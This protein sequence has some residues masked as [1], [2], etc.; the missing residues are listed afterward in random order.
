MAVIMLHMMQEADLGLHEGMD[1]MATL[2]QSVISIRQA[3]V[4]DAQEIA[5]VHVDTW[6][7][8]YQGLIPDRVL[9][10]LTHRKRQGQW[11]RILAGKERLGT[12]V[13][14]AD[15]EIVGFAGRGRNRD[16]ASRFT[17]EIFT[18][19]V[20]QEWQ[21]FGLGKVL[22]DQSREA[23]SASGHDRM[24]IWVL[25]NNPATKFYEWQGGLTIAERDEP[26][27]GVMLRE[28]AY[29]WWL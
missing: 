24:I 3:E 20:L 7:E 13:A 6:R 16:I 18:L 10:T 22:F 4:A 12:L 2:S 25:A 9:Q 23:L 29:G 19:Y 17:G 28:R 15:G 8:T 11:R 1:K 26:M 27:G 14:E 5:R 21:G